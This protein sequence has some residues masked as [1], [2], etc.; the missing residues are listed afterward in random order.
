M[1]TAETKIHTDIRAVVFDLDD[2]LY[3]E[4][5]YVRSGYEA[6]AEYLSK[7]TRAEGVPNL[8]RE[9]F[10]GKLLQAFE[11]GPRDR[12]FNAVLDELGWTVTVEEIRELVRVYREHGPRLKLEPAV[13][14]VLKTLKQRFQL[15]LISDGFLPAQRLKAESLGLGK[16]FDAMIFTEELGREFW[17][18]HPRAFERME[19]ILECSAGQCVYVADNTEKDFIAPNGRGWRTVQ[20]LRPDRI[21]QTEEPPPGGE[22]QQVITEIDQLIPLL[23]AGERG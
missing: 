16:Y 22:A 20:I 6:V 15:G 13:R 19:E 4:R 5:A 14:K 18:P 2:T 8:T 23:I 10:L 1:K 12:V 11:T 7:Q 9:E 17:K 21:R 3:P